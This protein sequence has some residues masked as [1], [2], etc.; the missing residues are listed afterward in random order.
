VDKAAARVVLS[1]YVAASA[2]P[3][4]SADDLDALLDLYQTPDADGRLVSDDGWVPTWDL[5]AAAAEGWRW[6]AGRVAGDFNFSADN[7]SYSKE[8]TMA[9]CLAMATQ[10]AAKAGPFVTTF[11]DD[12]GTDPYQAPRLLVN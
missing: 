3:V 10:Y 1:N 9:H 5:N 12:R 6:K 11:R 4:L 8:S 7:A 2:R